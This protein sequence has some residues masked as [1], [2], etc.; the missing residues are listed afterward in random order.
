MNL[1]TIGK[2]TI[3]VP[4]LT[5]GCMS[6]GRDRKRTIQLLSKALDQGIIHL[7]TADLY[8]FGQNEILIGHFLKHH[9]DQ[10]VLTT[11]VGNHFNP[12]TKESFWDPSKKHIETAVVDSLKR[13]QIDY[14]DLYLLHGG[15]IHDPIDETIGAFEQLK[16]SGKIRTYGISSIRPNVIKA[17]MNHSNIDAVM[18]QYNML[19]R[20]PEE[21]LDDLYD[22]NISV[23]ARGPLAKGMISSQ[24]LS[25]VAKKGADGYLDYDKS[26]LAAT[27]TK[28]L[29]L[30]EPLEKLAFQYILHHRAVVSAVFG[31][32]NEEQLLENSRYL[33]VTNMSD[34]VYNKIQQMTKYSRYTKHLE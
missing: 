17:Y 4:N 32:S 2:S 19:D 14:I 31:A 6:L 10:I 29:T 27:V 23:L 5:L 18:M 28:L 3:Y 20:R 24:A 30:G 16:S 22:H 7:D 1:K 12:Q 25:Y 13:L 11:K 8:D 33:H 15:T 9:R 26:E 21:L 34:E